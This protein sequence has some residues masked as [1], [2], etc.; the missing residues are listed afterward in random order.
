MKLP[1]FLI[2]KSCTEEKPLLSPFVE[3][4]VQPASYDVTLGSTFLFMTE[5]DPIDLGEKVNTDGLYRKV[6]SDSMTLMPGQFVLAST[7][8]FFR[9]PSTLQ[10]S[11]SGKSSLGRLGLFVENAGFIDPGF[12]GT[13]TL[14]LYNAGRRALVLRKGMKIAQVSFDIL[15][16]SCSNPYGG[17]GRNSNYQLQEGA[18]GS[19][20]RNRD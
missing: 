17:S 19:R 2:L 5:G 9:V 1:D 8:E 6:I 7:Q 4:N 14:E 10:S 11:V 3:K 13:I 18:T 16:D 12:R 20:W 15:V